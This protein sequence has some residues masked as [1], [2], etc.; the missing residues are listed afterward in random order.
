MKKRTTQCPDCDKT[1]SLSAVKIHVGSK[2]CLKNQKEGLI[3][4][5]ICKHCQIDTSEMNPKVA[6]NHVRWCEKNPKRLEYNKD[7]SK[8]RE[9]L[10]GIDVW[11]KGLTKE[12]DQRVKVSS[13]TLK[14]KYDLGELTPT[15][16]GVLMSKEQKDKISKTQLNNKYQRVCKSTIEYNCKDGSIIKMDSSWEVTMAESLDKNNINWE[17]PS[18]LPWTDDKGVKHNY[19]PDFYVPE[20]DVFLDPKNDWV[21][22]TQAPKLKCL[23]EQYNNIFIL[24][25]NDLSVEKVLELIK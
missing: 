2:A 23:S 1:I 22:K 19:F 5:G 24:G 15:N 4:K 7:L 14:G 6:A 11:N 20:W 25:K 3:T 16:K 10:V 12:T 13:Q 17:R 18:P 9:A 21:I 8:A